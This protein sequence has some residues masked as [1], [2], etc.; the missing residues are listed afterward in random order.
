MKPLSFERRVFRAS[1]PAATER[2]GSRLAARLGRGAV[3]GFSGD[4]GS[5]K[6]TMIR[7]MVRRLC[8]VEAWSPSFVLLHEYPG[9][10]PVFHADFYR[11]SGGIELETVGW[12]EYAGR[13]ILLVEWADRIPD[14]LPPGA[15][16][17]RI[18]IESRRSRLIERGSPG[19]L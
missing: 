19:A 2:L 9:P 12:P 5:G 13:G 14:G 17:V 11:L 7:G 6:T 18:G 15:V 4:L 16:R 3:V 8:G 1:G 10:V